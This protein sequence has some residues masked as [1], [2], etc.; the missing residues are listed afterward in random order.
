MVELRWSESAVE[1]LEEL[2]NYIAS[3]S[4]EYARNIARRII[5]TVE[6][7]ATFSPTQEG[8]CPNIIMKSG[9]KYY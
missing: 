2:C 6:T 3:D 5:D 7:V 8:L 9:K 1:D 4:E